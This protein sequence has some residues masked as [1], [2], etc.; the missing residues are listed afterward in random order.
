MERTKS[1]KEVDNVIEISYDSEPSG[2]VCL[3][4]PTVENPEGLKMLNDFLRE[5]A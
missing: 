1:K 3:I 2:H 4:D 5:F